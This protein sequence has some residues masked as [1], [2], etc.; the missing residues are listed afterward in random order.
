MEL[1]TRV[2]DLDDDDPSTG[3]VIRIPE[4]KTIADWTYTRDG[5]E[6]SSAEDNPDYSSDAQLVNVTFE[7]YLDERWPEWTDADPEDYWEGV[8]ENNVSIYA[9][10]RPRLGYLYPPSQLEPV[11][12][13]LADS[14]DA[15]EWQPSNQ[16]L[17]F[18]KLSEGYTIAPDGTVEGDGAYT[19][20][21]QGIVDDVIGETAAH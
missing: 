11:V 15:L 3:V 18:E 17:Y 4:G 5:E 8:K 16:Q 7:S 2:I 19:D 21:F 10:P 12:A 13:R 14:V 6:V 1:G 9:F 20:R